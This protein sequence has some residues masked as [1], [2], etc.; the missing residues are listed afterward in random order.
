[1]RRGLG[2]ALF[3]HLKCGE[4]VG[5]NVGNLNRISFQM[6]FAVE[7]PDVGVALVEMDFSIIHIIKM[8]I[9]KGNRHGGFACGGEKIDVGIFEGDGR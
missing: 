2:V 4:T 5:R 1:M 3:G 6:S 8:H 7:E 9:G